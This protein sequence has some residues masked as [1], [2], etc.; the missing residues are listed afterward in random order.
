MEVETWVLPVM[1]VDVTKQSALLM[2][3]NTKPQTRSACQLARPCGL[4]GFS[5]TVESFYDSKVLPGRTTW[6][7]YGIVIAL[8]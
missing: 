7:S 3:C 2:V 1:F 6:L 4:L 5:T 8:C